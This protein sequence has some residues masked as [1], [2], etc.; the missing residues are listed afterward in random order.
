MS[1]PASPKLVRIFLYL[2]RARVWIA[3]AFLILTA[4]G[5][6][7]A[8]RVPSD[9][10][11][12]RLIVPGDA[13]ARATSEFDRLFPE[14]DQALIML[15]APDPLSLAALRAADRLE[16]ELARIP[17]VAA[18]SLL[19]LYRR[20]GPTGELSAIDA[21]QLLRFATGTPLFRRAGL[22]GDHYLG[23]ALELRVNSP[24]ERN[25]ALTAIDSLALPLEA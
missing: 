1:V 7:G 12:E 23:I 5:I 14:G 25:R 15:E 6:Y 21:E 10:A 13:V 17:N 8:L 16:H 11:I 24:V 4:A 2:L 18:H 3:G 19:D 22:L 9:S 20:A